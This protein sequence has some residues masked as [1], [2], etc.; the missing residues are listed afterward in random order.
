MYINDTFSDSLQ[1]QFKYL[2]P[3]FKAIGLPQCV[4]ILLCFAAFKACEIVRSMLIKDWTEDKSLNNLTLLPGES[5]ERYQ[6]NQYYIQM[7]ALF[8]LVHC[9]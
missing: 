6:E 9:K 2:A 7:F 5:D 8:G 4:M 3:Y 1:V